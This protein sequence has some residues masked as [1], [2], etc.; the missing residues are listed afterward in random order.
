M[1]KAGDWEIKVSE[2]HPAWCELFYQGRSVLRGIH[3]KELRDLEYAVG[4]AI[5]EARGK[6]PPSYKHE[7]D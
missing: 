2:P 5:F 6:L 7:M 3:H 4:R 1:S